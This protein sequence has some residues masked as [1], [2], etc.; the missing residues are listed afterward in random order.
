MDCITCNISTYRRNGRLWMNKIGLN[1]N[2]RYVVVAKRYKRGRYD[3]YS[4]CHDEK[5]VY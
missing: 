3:K 5:I 2:E 1:D 4:I